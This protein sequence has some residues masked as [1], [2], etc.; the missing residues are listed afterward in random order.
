MNIN[1]FA[2]GFQLTPDQISAL[3]SGVPGFAGRSIEV[4]MDK[5]TASARLAE[6]QKYDPNASLN[7][8]A[9]TEYSNE[10]GQGVNPDQYTLNFDLSKMPKLTNQAA[11]DTQ[12][13]GLATGDYSKYGL[14]SFNPT[15]STFNSGSPYGGHSWLSDPSQVFKDDTYGS[16]TPSANL[17]S[18]Y[19]GTANDKYNDM[20]GKAIA[21]GALGVMGGGVAAALGGGFGGAL[22]AGAFKTGVNSLISGQSGPRFYWQHRR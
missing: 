15:D 3:Y 21:T 16:I 10:S 19:T 4:P 12:R 14:A 13:Q 5:D 1:D 20:I 7:T 9:G 6:V 22:G 11:I 8:I 18:L 17:H 2:A